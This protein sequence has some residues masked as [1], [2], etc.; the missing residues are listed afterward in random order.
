MRAAANL[1][2]QFGQQ[3]ANQVGALQGKAA[4]GMMLPG[5]G[6]QRPPPQ[7]HQY[8]QGQGQQQRPGQPQNAQ[9]YA[10]Q[11]QQN[12]ARQQQQGQQQQRPQ[13]PAQPRPGVGNG[14]T[15]GAG[16]AE[17]QW[18][19]VMMRRNAAGENEELGTVEVDGLIRRSVEQMG[20]QMEGGGLMLP[21]HE[22]F[23]D[24]KGKKRCRVVPRPATGTE[25]TIPI[26]SS[27]PIEAAGA[28]VSAIPQYDGGTGMKDEDDDDSEEEK[29]PVELDEDAINSDLDDDD[30]NLDDDEDEEIPQIML[31]MY[32]KVQRVKNKWKCVLKDGVLTVNNRE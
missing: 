31:C 4:A 24:K 14:Q 9:Q 3:A 21:L 8:P 26:L 32:D 5:A 17:E 30:E 29:K 12:Q 20:K 10:Q 27:R 18:S 2:Q 19:A 28:S 1:N 11:Q 13:Q 22:V 7:Q 25:M 23:P 16:D 15:D 6:G